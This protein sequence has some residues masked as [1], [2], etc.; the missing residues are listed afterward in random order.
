ME[1]KTI[2]TVV[3]MVKN[4]ATGIN[5]VESK[6]AINEL[7][8]KTNALIKENGELIREN[9]KLKQEIMEKDNEIERVK[10]CSEQMTYNK[11]RR[12]YIDKDGIEYCPNCYKNGKISAIAHTGMSMDYCT[13]CN[14]VI[15]R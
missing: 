6:Q 13:K 1:L 15:G 10:S 7:C 14:W 2:A 12:L 5:D 8:D 4:I 11:N 3:G 9:N